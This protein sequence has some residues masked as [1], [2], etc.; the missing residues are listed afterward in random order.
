MSGPLSVFILDS[1]NP[2][3]AKLKKIYD[4]IIFY[5]RQVDIA[6]TYSISTTSSYN[7]KGEKETSV[8]H[9][10]EIYSI[11]DSS[12]PRYFGEAQL[13]NALLSSATNSLFSPPYNQPHQ[14]PNGILNQYTLPVSTAEITQEIFYE[15]FRFYR[16]LIK[17][18]D[19]YEKILDWNDWKIW[20]GTIPAGII[21]PGDISPWML[22]NNG[23]FEPTDY[24]F[25]WPAGINPPNSWV[26]TKSTDGTPYIFVGFFMYRFSSNTGYGADYMTVYYKLT[27]AEYEAG[28]V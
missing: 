1:G 16:N 19:E 17:V 22:Y 14:R 13:E 18:Y 25:V 7:S 26:V 20:T 4:N 6:N 10:Y 8:I 5:A 27:N 23:I 9:S 11:I 15:R 21:S 24:P 12:D 28:I 2:E 3:F